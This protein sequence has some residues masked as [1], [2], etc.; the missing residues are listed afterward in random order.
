V[1]AH[2]DSVRRDEKTVSGRE[3]M[4]DPRYWV[5]TGPLQVREGRWADMLNFV[6]LKRVLG[7]A[8]LR[9]QT[10]LHGREGDLQGKEVNSRVREAA[11]QAW[12]SMTPEERQVWQDR[13]D[14][15]L[16]SVDTV[17]K[18][19][20]DGIVTKAMREERQIE[21][22]FNG[23]L[24]NLERD[25]ADGR[26]KQADYDSGVVAAMNKTS[27]TDGAKKRGLPRST[28]LALHAVSLATRTHPWR[29]TTSPARAATRWCA[30]LRSCSPTTCRTRAWSWSRTRTSTAAATSRRRT[31]SRSAV[32][33]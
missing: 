23:V 9:E 30:Q 5:S 22:E 6:S 10:L 32:A 15:R 31:R 16:N 12:Q 17:K 33:A 27:R 29:W 18:T 13:I 7:L 24:D 4:E 11:K 2:D 19:L 8:S 21:G 26:I 28:R 20:G 25:L 1:S 3:P 14:S